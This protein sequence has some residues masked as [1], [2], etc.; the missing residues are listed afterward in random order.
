[1]KMKRRMLFALAAMCV[2]SVFAAEGAFPHVWTSTGGCRTAEEFEQMAAD[3]V[4]HGVQVV[5]SR[6]GNPDFLA[7]QL[8]ICR[9]YG[10]KMFFG[11][12]DP[13]KTDN[14]AKKSG[15]YEL[16]VMSGGC[17]RGLAIDRNLFAFTPGRHEI[18]VEPPVYSRDQAYAKH[19]HYYML[20][21][22]H[23]FGGYVPTGEAEVIVPERLF[24]GRQHL[25]ILP[26]KVDWA[27]PDAKPENDSAAHLAEA[28]EIKERRLV[29]ISFD[30]T[31]LEGCRLDKVGLAVYWAMDDKSPDWKP[32]RTCYSVFSRH[33]RQR[34]RWRVRAALDRWRKANGGT[35][36]ADVVIAVRLGD[37]IF[38]ATS[39]LNG[40]AVSFPLWDY[41]A[42]ARDAFAKATPE[43]VTYPRTWGAS[44]VYGPDACA[45][46][47]YLF[48]KACADYLKVAVDDFHAAVPTLQTFRNT[49]RGGVWSYGNDHDGTGQ[50][51]L[52]EVLDFLHLD[53]YPVHEGGYN[54]GCI[55]FDMA[56]MSGLA[57]RYNKRLVPCMW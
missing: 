55:P 44:E 53:P 35:F 10:L 52:A 21:D 17:Y 22:G 12:P 36:P 34:M 40:P 31:G 1:M 20:G 23:Y 9:K 3:C 13:S 42:S 47:L 54:G 7:A 29:R 51:L 41:S 11:I 32:D 24:D 14:D 16:A 37:E 6:N 5:A 43:G 25:R 30:L 57:R 28:K 2:A 46:F 56:Y 45:Q 33:T 18:I 38:N 49:T 4:A 8:A 15:L 27:P 39:F 26:A 50:E 19:P 48:H